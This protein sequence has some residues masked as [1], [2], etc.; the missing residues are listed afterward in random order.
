M[1]GWVWEWDSHL[2]IWNG[3]LGMG[4]GQSAIHMNGWLGMGMGQSAV[5]MNGWLG[6]GMGQS[7]VWNGLLGMGMGQQKGKRVGCPNA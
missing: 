2:S 6:M 5:H 3:C 4:M 1:G 7:L